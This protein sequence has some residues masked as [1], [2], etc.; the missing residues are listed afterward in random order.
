MNFDGAPAHDYFLSLQYSNLPIFMDTRESENWS[1]SCNDSL[2]EI[3]RTN[4]YYNSI[5]ATSGRL[6]LIL[7][8][9]M[10]ILF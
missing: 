7:S 3:L 8:A 6:I 10:G 5:G 1:S 2:L 9:Y 4:N